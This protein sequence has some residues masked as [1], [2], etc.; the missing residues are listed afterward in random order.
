MAEAAAI[1]LAGGQST[2]MGRDKAMV[3]IKE[4]R[5]LEGLVGVL[6]EAFA[7]IILSANDSTYDWLKIKTVPDIYDGRGPLGGIHAGLTASSYPINFLV[8]CDMP[9]INTGLAAYMTGLADRYDI[10]VPMIGKYYQPLFAVYTKN[11]LPAIE[12]Q[13]KEGRNKITSFYHHQKVRF[14]ELDEIRQYGNPDK[15]FFNV[16]TPIDLETAKTMAGR[17]KDGTEF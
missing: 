8:A 12:R 6:A 13:L 5:M 2:R 10:V 17:T 11:C 15:I 4:K 1:V 16:N 7:E 3:K 9:F 14:V